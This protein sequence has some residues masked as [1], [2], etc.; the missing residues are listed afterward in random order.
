[1]ATSPIKFPK[2][3]SG[4]NIDFV[5]VGRSG[6]KRFGGLV[7]QEFLTTLRGRAGIAVYR[8]MRDNDAVIGASLTILEQTIRKAN[9]FVELKEE[10]QLQK[11]AGNF[12]RECI[13]DMSHTWDD[14]ISEALTMFPFGWAWLEIVYKLRKGDVRDPRRRSKFNDGLVGLR[15]IALRMQTSFFRWEFDDNG[16]IQSMIQNPA[17]EFKFHNIPISKSI[18]FRTKKDGNNPE[19]RSLLRNAYRSWFIKKNIE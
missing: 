14:M 3:P 2:Q 10:T 15:K 7:Q 12:L 1:M 11:R 9:W 8:E 6:L 18:L 17:P 16:G 13:D 4:S 5:E 19:G